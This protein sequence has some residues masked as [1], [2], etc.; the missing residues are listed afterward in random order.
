MERQITAEELSAILQS[1]DFSIPQG[2]KWIL[3]KEF[4][5]RNDNWIAAVL[6]EREDKN[7]WVVITVMVQFARKQ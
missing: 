5:H 2:T 3:A 6:I 7:L 1:P 4:Q